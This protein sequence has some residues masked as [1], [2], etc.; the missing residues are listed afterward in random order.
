MALIHE[1]RWNLRTRYSHE[2]CLSCELICGLDI[3]LL[4]L[5]YLLT[6]FIETVWEG[7][8]LDYDVNDVSQDTD[9]LL[10]DNYFYVDSLTKV[11]DQLISYATKSSPEE[12]N[13]EYLTNHEIF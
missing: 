2:A 13:C 1:C 12:C 9:D 4:A 8:F 10:N 5:E 3:I 7:G 11:R 6:D